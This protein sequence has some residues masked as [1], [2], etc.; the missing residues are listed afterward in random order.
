[1]SG[2][3]IELLTLL[4]RNENGRARKTRPVGM[5]YR[6]WRVRRAGPH[7]NDLRENREFMAQEWALR[8]VTV[9]AILPGGDA[10]VWDPD[11]S[12]ANGSEMRA[13]DVWDSD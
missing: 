11:D 5:A 12:Q 3:T 4:R 10:A 8:G 6:E 2:A 13:E 9:H 7:K 1:M